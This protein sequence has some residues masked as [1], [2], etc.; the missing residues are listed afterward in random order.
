MAQA[1]QRGTND[2]ASSH[3]YLLSPD[4]VLMP[5]EDGTAQLVDLDGSFF[6]L[7]EIAAEMLKGTLDRG[8]EDTVHRIATEYNAGFEEVRSDLTELLTTLRAR[9]LIRRTDDSMRVVKLR[10]AIALGFSYP[11]LMVVWLVP[12]LHL[13]ATVLQAF[14]RLSFALAGWARTVEAWQKRLNRFHVAVASPAP[15]GF[16]DATEDAIRRSASD[17]PSIACKERALSC[18]FTLQSAGIPAA[19]VMGVQFSPF[20]GHCWCEVDG[21]IVADSAEQCKGYRPVIRYDR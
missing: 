15:E 6:G 5:V 8:E 4:V 10:T 17:R 3:R 2:L 1:G 13:K 20:S 14:A 12:N 11:A 7:S 16:I 21:R 9:G 19:L 18:W